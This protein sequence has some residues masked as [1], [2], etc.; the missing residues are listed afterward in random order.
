MW[1]GR[2]ADWRAEDVDMSF[3]DIVTFYREFWRRR[4]EADIRTESEMVRGRR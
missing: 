2:F 1:L 4:V 3:V